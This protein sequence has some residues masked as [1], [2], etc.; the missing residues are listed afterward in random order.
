MPLSLQLVTGPLAEPVTLAL[1]KAQCRVDLD[2]D[3]DLIQLYISVARAAAESYTQR[4]IFPQTWVR[5]LDHFPLWWSEYGTVNPAY[6]KDW[7]Y[8]SDFWNRIRIDLPRP[9][10]LAVV[11]ITYVDMNGNTQTLD[12]STYNVDLT[13]EPARIVPS[14]SN[15]WPSQMT[16]IPGSVKITYLSGSYVEV[17]TD[18]A[19]QVPAAAPFVLPLTQGFL[20]MISL[21]QM[22]EGQPVAVPFTVA[23]GQ[24][25]VAEAFAAASLN[26]QYYAPPAASAGGGLANIV[27]AML[28]TIGHL[29]NHRESVSELPLKD[30][31]SSARFYLDFEKFD[32]M[33]Y[34]PA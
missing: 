23:N 29:Y 32:V 17:Q 9:R 26:A 21:T 15:Y 2:D 4:A 34:A 7:P 13:S 28:L 6:R 22:V 20:G 27:I 31:P 12:P 33:E 14:F 16:Y 11:S 3:D 30:V 8:Y 10:T 5:T 24:V 1:A 19:I 25:S 18:S